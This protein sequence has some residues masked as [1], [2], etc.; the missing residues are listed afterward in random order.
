MIWTTLNEGMASIS[1]PQVKIPIKDYSLIATLTGD[2]TETVSEIRPDYHHLPKYSYIS[3]HYLLESNFSQVL[4]KLKND[5]KIA[6][7]KAI[8]SQVCLSVRNG[9]SYCTNTYVYRKKR[10]I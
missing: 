2:D 6:P 3:R 4:T 8:C 9:L 1:M 5:D 10:C 7:F